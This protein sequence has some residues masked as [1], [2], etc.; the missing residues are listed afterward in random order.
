MATP[1]YYR[2]KAAENQAKADQARRKN[3]LDLEKEYLKRV[4]QYEELADNAE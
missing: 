4:K 2:V 3:R 1:E